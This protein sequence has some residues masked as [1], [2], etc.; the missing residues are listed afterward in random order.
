MLDGERAICSVLDLRRAAQ[1]AR[2]SIRFVLQGHIDI[3]GDVLHRDGELI[4]VDLVRYVLQD[5][6]AIAIGKRDLEIRLDIQAAAPANSS[7]VVFTGGS[8][9]AEAGMAL[10]EAK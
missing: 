8:N 6:I 7:G 9:A 5:Q 4:A 2:F 3:E 10:A 1:D